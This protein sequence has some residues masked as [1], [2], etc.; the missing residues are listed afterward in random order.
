MGY[1]S[2]YIYEETILFERYGF[3]YCFLLVSVTW[4]G[5]GS[6]LSM[7]HLVFH[8]QG[9][10]VMFIIWI[11]IG[12]NRQC[13][14]TIIPRYMLHNIPYL[15]ALSIFWAVWHTYRLSETGQNMNTWRHRDVITTVIIHACFEFYVWFWDCSFV[16]YYDSNRILLLQHH[17]SPSGVFA[18]YI[19]CAVCR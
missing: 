2:I 4:S 13:K 19:P 9:S 12:L 10:V 8:P 15:I 5:L 6:E 14:L 7:F 16:G 18:N 17:F 11:H 1:I 3:T